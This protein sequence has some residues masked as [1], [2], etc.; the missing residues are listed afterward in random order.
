MQREGDD[1]RGRDGCNTQAHRGHQ[2]SISDH[3]TVACSDRWIATSGPRPHHSAGDRSIWG[4][5]ATFPCNARIHRPQARSP[6]RLFDQRIPAFP[7]F[8]TLSSG[9]FSR[10]TSPP[11][12]IEESLLEDAEEQLARPKEEV[13]TDSATDFR[14]GLPERHTRGPPNS[15]LCV[16]AV[17]SAQ[18]P[19]PWNDTKARHC[20]IV[21]SSSFTSPCTEQAFI[22]ITTGNPDKNPC[23]QSE[24]LSASHSRGSETQDIRL[25]H[26]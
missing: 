25:P 12:S 18:S 22:S 14:T 16:P 7:Y 5:E 23:F 3:S 21:L 11:S 17:H 8:S 26:R 10:S 6:L 19:W 20:T 24:V 15:H 4:Y 1:H 2:V 9:C 13:G